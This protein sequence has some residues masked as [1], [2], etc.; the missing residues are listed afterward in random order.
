MQWSEMQ[1][2]VTISVDDAHMVVKGQGHRKH[3]QQALAQRQSVP[4]T[5]STSLGELA[6][7][8]SGTGKYKR[9]CARVKLELEEFN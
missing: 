6:H 5:L 9:E 3:G 2:L 4:G 8:Q 7:A 1:I